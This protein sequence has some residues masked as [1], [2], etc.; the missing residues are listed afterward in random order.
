MGGLLLER[1][2]RLPTVGDE[3][4]IEGL[5]FKIRRVLDRYVVSA[6]VDTRACR[7]SVG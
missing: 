3:L 5:R 4:V 7:S 2:G 1:F 6:L